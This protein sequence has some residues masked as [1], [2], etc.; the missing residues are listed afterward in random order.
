MAT[1][2]DAATAERIVARDC[3]RLADKDASALT[4]CRGLLLTAERLDLPVHLL[5]LRNSGD[6][7]G[8]ATES[9]VTARCAVG[10]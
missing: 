6:S 3:R 1:A 5:D 7:A 2:R 9:W 8:P 4:H 10:T